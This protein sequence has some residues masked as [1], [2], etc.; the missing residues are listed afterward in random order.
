MTVAAM[1]RPPKVARQSSAE[2]VRLALSGDWT[3]FASQRLEEEGRRIVE[4]ARLDRTIAVDLSQVSQLDTAGAWLINRARHDLARRDVAVTLEHVR[5]EYSTLLEETR[6]RDF[7]APS[8]PRFNVIFV[9]LAD[10]GESIVDALREFY[11]GVGFLGEFVSSMIYVASNP[12]RFRL[13]S[14]VAQIELVGFRSVPI[15]VLINILVGGIVA[16]QGIFQLLKF[17]ASSYTVSLIGILVLRELGVLLTSIMIAGRSGSAIT[18]E[19]GSMK[20]REEVDALL[21]MGLSPFEVLI[22]PR[23]LGLVISLPILTFVADMAALFGGMLVAWWYGGIS[24]AAFASLLKEAIALHTFLVGIIKAPFMALV[25]GLIASMDGL[26]TQGSAE[27]LGRQ[28]TSSVVKS[29]FMVI[30]MDGVFA[31][32]FAA[33]DY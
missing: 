30:V 25:I 26:A 19:L 1:Q 7:A 18:A 2:G 4:E 23:V 27:S 8:R 13:T 24:P 28:V 6:Y 29:I 5:P 15:I 14:L 31:V 9:L 16:Q 17:G 12:R 21:V 22:A 11:R 32:F 33:I 20:M 3:L 10:F